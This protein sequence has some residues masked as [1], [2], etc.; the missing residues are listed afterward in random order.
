MS[1][2]FN[3][4][5]GDSKDDDGE[6]LDETKT[7]LTFQQLLATT[8]NRPI[9]TIREKDIIISIKYFIIALI[10][11]HT[12]TPTDSF[13]NTLIDNQIKKKKQQQH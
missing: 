6:I 3:Y 4:I 10:R 2:Y 12:I 11:K 8:T 9:S 5:N 1:E 7:V 13:I